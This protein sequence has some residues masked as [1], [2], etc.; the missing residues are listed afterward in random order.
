MAE[1]TDARDVTAKKA[2]ARKVPA[3]KASAKAAAPRKAAGEDRQ[4][5]NNEAGSHQSGNQQS[6]TQQP[7]SNQ[8]RPP[9]GGVV[10]AR[11]AEQLIELIGKEAEGVVGLERTDDGWRVLVEV[12]E[13]RR[14]PTTTDVLA[15]Y[16]VRVDPSG[17][18]EGYRRLQRYARGATRDE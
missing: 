12:L 3:K 4:P 11:A 2:P 1:D 9:K 6:G 15:T 5:G 18:L 13:L 14:V 17:D 8:P 7:G 10:A 16:E